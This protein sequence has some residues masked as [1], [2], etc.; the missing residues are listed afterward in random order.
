[1]PKT[2]R[3]EC[4]DCLVSGRLP[5]P[6][7]DG[8]GKLGGLFGVIGAKPCATCGGVG[9]VLCPGCDS[10]PGHAACPASAGLSSAAS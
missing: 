10:P 5:C 2:V 1:M 7:C 4:P 6:G 3:E 9:T 8:R